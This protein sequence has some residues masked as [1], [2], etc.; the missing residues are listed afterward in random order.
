MP[1]SAGVRISSLVSVAILAVLAFCCLQP[2]T[3][4]AAGEHGTLIR[5]ADIYLTPDK[6]SQ[7]L[8]EIERGRELVV[9]ENSSNGWAHVEVF[10]SEEKTVS[11]WILD[12][13][14]VRSTNP[15]GDQIVFG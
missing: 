3:V 15:D 12:K 5:V 11:G 7:K 10:L 14:F 1:I 9:L 4:E 2:S 8:A 13:G 6:N